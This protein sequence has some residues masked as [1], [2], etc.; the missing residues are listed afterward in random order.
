M[1]KYAYTCGNCG[2]SAS[3]KYAGT[4]YCSD[5]CRESAAYKRTNTCKECGRE[6]VWLMAK[7]GRNCPVNK[8]SVEEGDWA[9]TP[10]RGHMLHLLTCKKGTEN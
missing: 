6:F 8:D 3:S 5:E 2:K 9:Y 4:K 10:S 7:T 1:K